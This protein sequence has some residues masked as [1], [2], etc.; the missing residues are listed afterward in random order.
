MERYGKI[1]EKTMEEIKEAGLSV[2]KDQYGE[3]EVIAK[4]PVREDAKKLTEYKDIGQDMAEYQ[5]WVDYDMERYGKISDRTM[6]EI[7]KAGLSIVKDQYGNY[8]VI[9]YS[10]HISEEKGKKCEKSKMRD[11]KKLEERMWRYTLGAGKDIRDAIDEEDYE[12][13]KEA[14]IKAYKEI[15]KKDP[16]LFDDDELEEIINDLESMDNDEDAINY[17]LSEFYDLCDNLGI[18]ISPV[19][20]EEDKDEMITEDRKGADIYN[21]LVG[22]LRGEEK[23]SEITE[24][25][26]SKKGKSALVENKTRKNNTR[27]SSLLEKMN[28]SIENKYN[29]YLK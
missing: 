13:T 22:A 29:K 27:F 2:T 15:N 23:S 7:R 18:W 25:A 9:A 16:D 4:E 1:S 5:K 12:G 11:R 6:E 8:A 10:K 3:Y 28:N 14:L 19:K 21:K 24:S 26:K 20:M 17:E